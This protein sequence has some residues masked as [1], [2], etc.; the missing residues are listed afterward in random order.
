MNI[1]ASI[2][3]QRVLALSEEYSDLLVGKGISVA[4]NDKKNQ[5][6]LL[7]CV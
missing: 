7:R 6:H 2:V 5:R 4:D 1:N 3:D